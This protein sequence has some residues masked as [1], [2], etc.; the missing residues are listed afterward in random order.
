MLVSI[1]GLS[2]VLTYLE[3]ARSVIRVIGAGWEQ[4]EKVSGR[5][6]LLELELEKVTGRKG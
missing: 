5:T 1:W 4:L 6:G 2:F 3:T